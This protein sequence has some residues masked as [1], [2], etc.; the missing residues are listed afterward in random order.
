MVDINFVLGGEADGRRGGWGGV[1]AR[2]LMKAM[3]GF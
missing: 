3:H 1:V 2:L